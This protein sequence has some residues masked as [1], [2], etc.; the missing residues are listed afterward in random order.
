MERL[1]WNVLSVAGKN[2][3]A[4]RSLN[5]KVAGAV[6]KAWSQRVQKNTMT[7]LPEK[8]MDVIEIISLKRVFLSELSDT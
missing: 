2:G 4:L 5:I 8:R 6:E 7:S 1:N 3:L